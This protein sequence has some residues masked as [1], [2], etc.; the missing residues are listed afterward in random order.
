MRQA[1][2]VSFTA[3]IIAVGALSASVSTAQKS[4]QAKSLKFEVAERDEL[5]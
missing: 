1:V 4:E 3:A 2:L 5:K